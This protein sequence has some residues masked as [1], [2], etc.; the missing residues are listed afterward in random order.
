MS[1]LFKHVRGKDEFNAI[2]PK[3]GLTVAVEGM[4]YEIFQQSFFNLLNK[5]FTLTVKI[6]FA[7][8]S[9]KDSFVKKTGRELALSRLEEFQIKPIALV[10]NELMF[11]I[12]GTSQVLSFTLTPRNNIILTQLLFDK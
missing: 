7:I 3:G 2:L 12:L 4:N 6:G 10:K 9:D 5:D 11:L 1:V 8:C